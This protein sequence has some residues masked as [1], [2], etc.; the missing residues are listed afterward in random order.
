MLDIVAPPEPPTLVALGDDD[1]R[2]RIRSRLWQIWM[3]LVTV[4][5]TAWLCTLGPIPA[6]VALVTAKHVLVAILAMGLCVDAPRDQ[7]WPH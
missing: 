1:H 3:T 7:A 4:L 2:D 5:A 6:V